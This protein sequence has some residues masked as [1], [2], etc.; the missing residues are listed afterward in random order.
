MSM[1]HVLVGICIGLA[2]GALIGYAFRQQSANQPLVLGNGQIQGIFFSPH[3]GCE[4]EVVRWIQRANASVHVLIY[5]FTL[6]LIGD[7]LVDA[8]NRNID[9]KVVFEQSQISEY[10]QY[11]RLKSN[12]IDVRNDTNSNLMHDKVMVVDGVVVLTGSFNWS[13]SAEESNNENL[14]V[15]YGSDT[16]SIYQN[17]FWKIWNSSV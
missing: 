10:S 7:A 16:A 9:V 6:D 14:I 13:N 17:E 12:G 8:H 1:K 11:S 2:L 5:S 3:G 4:A 15:V